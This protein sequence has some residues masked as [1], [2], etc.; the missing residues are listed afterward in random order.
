MWQDIQ[1]L[2]EVRMGMSV[3]SRLTIS[4]NDQVKKFVKKLNQD[5]I[6]D[7]KKNGSRNE[8][9]RRRIIYN[10]PLEIANWLSSSENTKRIYFMDESSFRSIENSITFV[11]QGST[12]EE[13]Q[14]Y[15]LITLSRL[16]PWVL[17]CNQYYNDSLSSITTRYSLMH[18]LS[19]D[20][21]ETYV[22]VKAPNVES[23]AFYNRITKMRLKEKEKAFKLV[24]KQFN[25]IK[26][27]RYI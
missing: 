18:D 7:Y 22:E 20:E 3:T 6:N 23:D 10:H 9:S 11:S 26:D 8:T 1:K 17:I 12:I 25:W 21:V 27:D 13:L 16:D 14:D 15:L 19:P 24:K 2:R 5:F 4:G